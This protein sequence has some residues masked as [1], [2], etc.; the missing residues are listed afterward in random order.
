MIKTVL[1]KKTYW[2]P[3]KQSEIPYKMGK[4]I[5]EIIDEFGCGCNPEA[6]KWIVSELLGCTYE[7]ADLLTDE[8]LSIIVDTHKM[9]DD[10]LYIRHQKQIKVNGV[11]YEYMDFQKPMSVQTFSDLDLLAINEEH[12]EL[13]Q[14]LFIPTD[15]KTVL[16]N[17]KSWEDMNYFQH[18]LSLYYYF[19]WK[20][21]LLDYY[22]VNADNSEIPDDQKDSKYELNTLEKYGLYHVILELHDN[23][24]K[25]LHWW[26]ERDIREFLKFLHYVNLKALTQSKKPV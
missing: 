2:L 6:Q 14:R 12:L 16:K 4:R 21:E 22:S 19:K 1:N 3:L 20:R 17:H 25:M 11:V 13:V 23:D 24:I 9:F 26:L 7:E 8:Q 15:K 5:F 18:K 10:E